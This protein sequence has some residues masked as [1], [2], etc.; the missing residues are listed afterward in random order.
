M[1]EP[2]VIWPSEPA[3]WRIHSG[4]VLE[5]ISNLLRDEADDR[6]APRAALTKHLSLSLSRTQE[7]PTTK[8]PE[9]HL[10]STFGLSLFEVAVLW[11]AVAPHLEPG[12]RGWLTKLQGNSLHDFVDGGLCLRLLCEDG[13]DRL[14]HQEYFAPHAPLFRSRLLTL[15]RREVG[16]SYALTQELSPAGH[17]LGWFLGQRRTSEI[18]SAFCERVAPPPTP[19]EKS[20]T[21]LQLETNILPMLH[22]AWTTQT[23]TQTQNPPTAAIAA[24]VCG[25]SCPAAPRWA[26]LTQRPVLHINGPLLST[27]SP[28][29]IQRALHLAAQESSMYGELIVL[30]AADPFVHPDSPHAPHLADALRTQPHATAI[31]CIDDASKLHP[32]I[33]DL[34]LLRQ[35]LVT[36]HTPAN[37]LTLW[38]QALLSHGLPQ[39]LTQES[40]APAPEKEKEKPSKRR[41]DKKTLPAPAY[42]KTPSQLEQATSAAAQQLSLTPGQIE[43]AARLASLLHTA[44]P[45]RAQDF[46]TLL[47]KAGQ[48]QI[49]Q[50]VGSLA[51][52]NEA[53]LGFEGLILDAQTTRQLREILAAIRSRQLVIH[54]WRLGERIR[55]GTGITCLFD[56]DPGTG[57]TL[58]AEVIAAEA[59]LDLLRVNVSTIVDKYIGETEK[60]LAQIFEQV[61]PDVSLLLFDEADSLFAKRTEVSKSSDRYANMEINVLLQLI[62]RYE[63][64]TVLTTNLKRSI[65]PAFERRITF[66]VSFPMPDAPERLAIWRHLLPSHVPTGDAL[67]YEFLAESMELTGGEIKNAILRAAYAAACDGDLLSM[68]H[69]RD[70][71]RREATAT[72]RLVRDDYGE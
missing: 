15:R 68:R 28:F 40:P 67:D 64:V 31:L 57:K 11:L 16:A 49:T 24:A 47:K 9:Q 12:L 72:G 45:E 17:L 2:F 55:R 54:Q 3:V 52:R 62:E 7:N 61:R 48:A 21:E 27:A 56:G 50:H 37:S 58:S 44:Q 22:G 10:I 33:L 4:E 26:A 32:Q 14:S 13:I 59:G 69:L 1:S 30:R 29:E 23:Q 41:A 8:L 65:D 43:R 53:T 25:D 5:L 63:G 39:A 46:P 71:A 20:P 42:N 18:L 6:P 38:S 70:A 51:E 36:A 66:K 34:I 60:H 19:I 35:T